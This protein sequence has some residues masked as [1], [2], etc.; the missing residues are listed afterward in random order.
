MT[1]W[2][3]GGG[4]FESVPRTRFDSDIII[5]KFN[6]NRELLWL[7]QIGASSNIILETGN[8]IELDENLQCIYVTG[9]FL[10]SADFGGTTLQSNDENIFFAKYRFDGSLVWAKKMGS[11]S[12]A[13]S[14][15][16]TGK[17][18]FVDSEGFVFLAGSIGKNGNF[19]GI[20]ISAY[21]DP[22]ISNSYFDPFLAKYDASGKLYWVE[23]FGSTGED[24]IY[25]L[26]KEANNIYVCGS[27][28]PGAKF[29][30]FTLSGS[31][32]SSIGY[33]AKIID[34]DDKTFSV[35]ISNAW[36]EPDANLKRSGEII[37]NLEWEMLPSEP[38]ISV[39][40]T[41]GY[42]NKIF[43]ISLDTNYVAQNREGKILLSSNSQTK[44]I[45]ISQLKSNKVEVITDLEDELKTSEIH[46]FP[47][48]VS[49]IL[50][51]VVPEDFFTLS[52]SI[53]NQIGNLVWRSDYP[54]FEVDVSGFKSGLYTLKV[55]SKAGEFIKKFIK[56]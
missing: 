10:G 7:K 42:G 50:N 25:G 51:L 19:D 46:L 1:G 12:G 32:R 34:R 13:A 54:V 31:D 53:T 56:I 28:Y 30:N 41:S 24:E 29:G 8:D 4:T 35:S 15:I 45:F 37:S 39:N 17:K 3:Y 47:N 5:A 33:V 23:H 9:G 21:Q 2:W 6:P 36:Y 48:P 38:W 44:V 14:Y 11:W 55:K 43:E 26:V 27:S 18:L 16:E 40:P 52:I 22:T 20:S 49:T